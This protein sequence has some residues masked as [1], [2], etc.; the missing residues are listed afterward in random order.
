MGGEEKVNVTSVSGDELLKQILIELKIANLH[1]SSV[2]DEE[3][4]ESDIS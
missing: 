1:L 4:T 3:I 2:T